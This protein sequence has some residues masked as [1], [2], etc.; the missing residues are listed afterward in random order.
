MNIE[1]GAPWLFLPPIPRSA[2]T[3]A[4]WMSAAQTELVL[5]CLN[6]PSCFGAQRV[7]D[8]GGS[9]HGHDAHSPEA[10]ARRWKTFHCSS[11]APPLT[12]HLPHAT[13]SVMLIV[14]RYPL[15]PVA[16]QGTCSTGLYH[17]SQQ[18]VIPGS[19]WVRMRGWLRGTVY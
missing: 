10:A 1:A 2:Q 11:T 13:P 15:L 16:V 3:Q 17:Y 6:P 5:Y 9:R 12:F 14:P 8:E 4:G 19:K 7:R 18:R